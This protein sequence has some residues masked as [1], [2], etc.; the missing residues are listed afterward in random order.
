[1]AERFEI[2]RSVKARKLNE[3]LNL[4]AEEK[5]ILQ[6][7]EKQWFF[8]EGIPGKYQLLLSSIP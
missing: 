7:G 1:M 8:A 3:W 6:L 2:E 5:N 4:G